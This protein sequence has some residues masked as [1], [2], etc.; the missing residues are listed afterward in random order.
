MSDTKLE[1]K[2]IE[3]EPTQEEIAEER[4]L[5]KRVT[6]AI[7]ID[8]LASIQPEKV[9]QIMESRMKALESIRLGAIRAT[10]P[11]NW[12][13]NRD[14]E[15]HVIA[16]LRRS[17][18]ENV[19]K[20]YGISTINVRPQEVVIR[21][22]DEGGYTA[23]IWGDGHC[24]LTGE[25][26]MNVRGARGSKEEFVGRG[27]MDDLRE[28]ARTNLETKIVRILSGTSS[29]SVQELQSA[30]SESVKRVEDCYR[31]HGYGKSSER[32]GD[33]TPDALS[34]YIKT[35]SEAKKIPEAKL[36]QE[37]TIYT[38]KNGTKA[39]AKAVSDLRYGWQIEKA[40]Q[41]LQEKYP[42]VPSSKPEP[43]VTPE[44]QEPSPL[45]SGAELFGVDQP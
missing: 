15:G 3:T 22:N 20:Y 45:P 11:H 14:K 13:L 25:Q 6:M 16:T 44:T 37:A 1:V 33:L 41:R 7:S 8:R 10:Q 40:I 17:G 36:L 32:G 23:E 9:V 34:A 21:K 26:I 27:T 4:N 12:T 5:S 38:T 35:I 42:D 24:G 18:A 29:V 43:E 39:W 28:S 19:R 2:P 30:W 31:G